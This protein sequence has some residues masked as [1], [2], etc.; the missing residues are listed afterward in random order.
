MARQEEF[1]QLT[2]AERRKRYFS[3]DIRKR[4]V[5]DLDRGIA[6]IAEVTREYQV[7]RTSIYRWIYTYSSMK[8]KGKKMVVEAKSDTRKMQLLHERIKE[9][10]QMVGQKQ[11]EI[12]FLNKMIE[13]TEKDLDIKIKKKDGI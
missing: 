11:V 12:E 4:I 7:S 5:R 8:K 13:L 6:T 10:E 1:L 3:E 9:L 2:L